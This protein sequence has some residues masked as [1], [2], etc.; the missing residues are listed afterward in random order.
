MPYPPGILARGPWPPGRVSG[1]WSERDYVPPPEKEAAADAAIAALLDRGSPAHDGMAARLAGFEARD[2]DEQLVARGAT[3]L[4][5]A[6]NLERPRDQSVEA[7]HVGVDDDHVELLLEHT[8]D[9]T[10]ARWAA[11]RERD[12]FERVIGLPLTIRD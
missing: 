10:V 5:L 9:V 3:M 1:R 2:G 7:A 12:L 6:E 11:E 8:E 4:R